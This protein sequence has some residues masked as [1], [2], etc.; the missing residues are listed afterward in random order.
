MKLLIFLS[1]S[2]WILAKGDKKTRNV[3]NERKFK[4]CVS[5]FCL[6]NNYR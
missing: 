5:G 3:T 6:P 1:T 2:D 4:T